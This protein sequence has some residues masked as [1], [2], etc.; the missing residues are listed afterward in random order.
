MKA[1]DKAMVAFVL[2]YFV[3][4][5]ITFFSG[6]NKTINLTNI[7]IPKLMMD[8][9]VWV[10]TYYLCYSYINFQA[11]SIKIKNQNKMK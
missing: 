11:N 10:I 7:D 9:G 2:T 3:A 8:F 5:A 1:K 4:R 6:Y